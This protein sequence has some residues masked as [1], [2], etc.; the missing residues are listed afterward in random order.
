[1]INDTTVENFYLHYTGESALAE[2]QSICDELQALASR[3]D[4]AGGIKDY[5]ADKWADPKGHPD[6]DEYI[7]LIAIQGLSILDIPGNVQVILDNT[8]K[9][10]ITEVDE[11][12]W[13]PAD[14]TDEINESEGD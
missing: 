9:L 12:G 5:K 14:A 7:V 13:F 2:A 8:A 3:P 11:G 6:K 4:Y 10:T 1:M